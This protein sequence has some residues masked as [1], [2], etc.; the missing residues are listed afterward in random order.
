MPSALRSRDRRE[1][2]VVTRPWHPSLVSKPNSF[3]QVNVPT[4]HGGKK[5]AMYEFPDACDD[6]G[7]LQSEAVTLTTGEGRELLGLQ[8]PSH[9]VPVVVAD[10]PAKLHNGNEKAVGAK[11]VR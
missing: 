9:S 5:M 8:H 2:A 1:V 3:V 7:V 6:E 10:Q 4:T 11:A